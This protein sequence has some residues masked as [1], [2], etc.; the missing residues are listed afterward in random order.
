MAIYSDRDI[1]TTFAGDIVLDR[2]GDLKLAN[3]LDTY[4]SAANFVLR[5][6]FGDYAPEPTVGCNL[7]SFIGRP[8]NQDS[9]EQM[10]YLINKVLQQELFALTDARADVVPFDVNEA[11]C[12]ISIAGSYLVDGEII[13]FD[14]EQMTY[15]FPFIDGEPT[16]LV[17][18]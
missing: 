16:P 18:S 11:L 3:A 4:K 14:A 9:H 6:D 13:Y 8:N 12:V 15:Q 7:G 5:T 1:E 17:V 2:K 10:E